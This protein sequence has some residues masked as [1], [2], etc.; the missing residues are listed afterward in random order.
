MMH[1]PAQYAYPS[2]QYEACCK[3]TGRLFTVTVQ[4]DWYDAGDIPTWDDPGSLP[5]VDFLICNHRHIPAPWLERAMDQEE[6]DNIRDK[7]LDVM[8]QGY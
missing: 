3:R 6:L 8:D 5:D 7:A 2:F 4:I 1:S